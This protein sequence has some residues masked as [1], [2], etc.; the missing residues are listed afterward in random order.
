MDK[1]HREK[2]GIEVE[3]D[4]KRLGYLTYRLWKDGMM[5]EENSCMN[6]WKDLNWLN[7]ELDINCVQKIAFK[8][9]QIRLLKQEIKAIKRF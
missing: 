9:E 2:T 3:A 8:K 7:K 5:I 4:E 6:F 1:P